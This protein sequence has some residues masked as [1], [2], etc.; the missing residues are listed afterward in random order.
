M[1]TLTVRLPDE[2]LYEVEINSKFL[3]VSKNAYIQEAINNLN[4]K[5]KSNF[6]REKLIKASQKVRNNSMEVN[7]EF[8]MIEDDPEI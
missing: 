2:T 3:H 4:E 7:S 1:P 8:S 6:K 5:I